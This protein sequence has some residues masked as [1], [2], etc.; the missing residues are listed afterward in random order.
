MQVEVGGLS[1]FGLA[2]PAAAVDMFSTPPREDRTVYV[3]DSSAAR[4]LKSFT[5]RMLKK[6]DSPLIRE[7]PKQPPAKSV[8]PWRSRRLAAQRLSRVLA[9]KRGEVL[10]MQR[11]G[12]IKGPLAP[13]ASELEAFNQIF[14]G[15]MTAS[16]VEALDALFSDGEKGSSRQP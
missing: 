7:P 1:A 10:I 12:Y 3:S 14:N 4:R 6:V 2:K 5:R 13:S 11:M 16:N 15:N 8:L 9:F